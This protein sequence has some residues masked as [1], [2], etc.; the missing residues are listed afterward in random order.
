MERYVDP[1]TV[2]ELAR[3]VVEEYEGDIT[4]ALESIGGLKKVRAIL[5]YDTNLAVM[6]P[7]LYY[8]PGMYKGDA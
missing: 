5:G 1:S 7:R 6:D 8:V 2:V 4:K 3:Y